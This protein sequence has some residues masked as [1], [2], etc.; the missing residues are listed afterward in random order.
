MSDIKRVSLRIDQLD[1]SHWCEWYFYNVPADVVESVVGLLRGGED[2]EI[3]NSVAY[4]E[5]KPPVRVT[6]TR[7]QLK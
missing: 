2:R 5:K 1:G 4:S 7:K 6:L 3:I